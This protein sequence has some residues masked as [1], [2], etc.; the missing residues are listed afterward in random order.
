MTLPVREAL[1][2]FEV[3]EERREGYTRDKFSYW[4]AGQ[5]TDGCNTRAE[6]LKSEAAIVTLAR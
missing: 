4:K 5:F 1:Q 2:A 3:Q 6:V